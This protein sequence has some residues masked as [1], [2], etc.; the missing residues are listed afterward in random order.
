MTVGA[1]CL[2]LVLGNHCELHTQGVQD[3]V[4]GFK[5]W[6]RART[7]GFVQAFSAQA[8]V[9]G[10]LGYASCLGYVAE[11]CDEYLGVRRVARPSR[12]LCERAGLLQA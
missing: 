10:D 8:R 12:V 5:A 7:Q 2:A 9:F 6:V 3:G 4:D 1:W 11:G